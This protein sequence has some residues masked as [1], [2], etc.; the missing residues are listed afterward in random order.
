ML[1]NDPVAIFAAWS[2]IFGEGPISPN[3]TKWR[4]PTLIL[5]GEGDDMF[6]NARKAAKEIPGARFIAMA[7]LDHFTAAEHVDD[8]LPEILR[9][10]ES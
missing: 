4:V 1:D 9:L 6:P 8:V 10:L 7:G 2:N 5:A 3:L